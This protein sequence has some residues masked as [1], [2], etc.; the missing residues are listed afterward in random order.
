MAAFLSVN[1]LCFRLS[2]G[3]PLFQNISF[4]A[5]QGMLAIVG[6]NGVGKSVLGRCL[7]GLLPTDSGSIQHQGQIH[8]VAQSGPTSAAVTVIDLFSVRR[9]YVAAR[10]VEQGLDD[11]NLLTQALNWWELSAEIFKHLRTVGLSDEV[12]SDTLGFELLR[13]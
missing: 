12:R 11:P 3:L 9:G 7:S 5:Q 10:K 1:D 8:Y 2:N 6:A 13:R 4:T